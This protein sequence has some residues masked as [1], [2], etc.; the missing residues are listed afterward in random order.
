MAETKL[1]KDQALEGAQLIEQLRKNDFDVTAACWLLDSDKE[2]WQL[3]IVSKTVSD[4]G[5][6]D[7]RKE[8]QSAFDQ[9]PDLWM[10]LSEVRLVDPTDRVAQEITA[11]QR[12]YPVKLKSRHRI[13]LG[14]MSS[15]DVH[16]YPLPAQPAPLSGS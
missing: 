9:L 6:V 1:V 11:I 14:G 16:V 13:K 7:A 8:L 12:R 10:D 15:A 4:K 2:D 5:R 3:F